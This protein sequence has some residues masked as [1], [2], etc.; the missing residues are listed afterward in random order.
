MILPSIKEFVKDYD[1]LY[2][3]AGIIFCKYNL[4]QW[5]KNDDGTVSCI[6]NRINSHKGNPPIIEIDGCCIN[7]CKYPKDFNDKII[8]RKQHNAKNGCNVKSLKCK[9]HI[10]EYLRNSNCLEIIEAV[11]QLDSLRKIFQL[12]YDIIWKSIPFGSSKKICIEIYR[13]YINKFK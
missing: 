7:T 2:K 6:V 11:K 13:K 9:L 5:I 10:C 12:K 8:K 4:C 1:S 3:Q